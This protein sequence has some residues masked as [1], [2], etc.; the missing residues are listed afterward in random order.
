MRAWAA[1]ASTRTDIQLT[2]REHRSRTHARARTHTHT[3]SQH[4][5]QYHLHYHRHPQHAYTYIHTRALTHTRTLPDELKWQCCRPGFLFVFNDVCSLV[6]RLLNFSVTYECISGANLLGQFINDARSHTN[7]EVAHKSCCLIQALAVSPRHMLLIPVQP[8]LAL[9]LCNAR[10]LVGSSLDDPFLGQGSLVWLICYFI[11]TNAGECGHPLKN[12]T[13]RIRERGVLCELLLRCDRFARHEGLQSWQWVCKT[14]F[15]RF[16][17]HEIMVSVAPPS[18]R[19]SR[20][21][22]SNQ[23]NHHIEHIRR[24]RLVWLDQETR[25]ATSVSPTGVLPPGNAASDPRVSHWH[26]TT[27]KRGQLSPCLPLTPYHQETRPAIPVS[28]TPDTDTLPPR[29]AASDL[30]VSHWRLTT[31]KRGQRS[32]WHLTTKKRGQQSL[33]LPLS[34]QAPHHQVTVLFQ[35]VYSSFFKICFNSFLMITGKLSVMIELFSMFSVHMNFILNLQK[36]CTYFETDTK[37]RHSV[38][39]VIASVFFDADYQPKETAHFCVSLLQH[40][41][42]RAIL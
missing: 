20:E 34:T 30:H 31:K 17:S 6:D 29:N 10:Q 3:H 25:P 8:V 9:T 14:V 28:P 38:V 18:M 4:H 40:N 41:Q 27:K 13:G 7:T 15:L 35:F 21:R 26:L 39:D 1:R 37:E 5:H 32:H 22:E 11:S 19:Q 23:R 33:C 16:S 42:W 36:R 12:N 2:Q 24:R